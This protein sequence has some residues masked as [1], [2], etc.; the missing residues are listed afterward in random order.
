VIKVSDFESP[1]QNW[2]EKSIQILG[3]QKKSRVMIQCFPR[4]GTIAG[5]SL[6]FDGQNQ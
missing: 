6:G 2:F 1:W 3:H 5:D 4:N